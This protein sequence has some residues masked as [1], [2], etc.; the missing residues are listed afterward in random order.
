MKRQTEEIVDQTAITLLTAAEI[1]L[2]VYPFARYFA[3]KYKLL[4]SEGTFLEGYAE[5]IVVSTAF[6]GLIVKT[7]EQLS[8]IEAEH[9]G[10]I[11]KKGECK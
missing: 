8:K 3:E 4:N 9:M 7:L 11:I 5:G 2:A 10:T 6:F 1:V